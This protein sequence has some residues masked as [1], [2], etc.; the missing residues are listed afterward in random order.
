M[1]VCYAFFFERNEKLNYL[2]FEMKNEQLLQHTH[3]NWHHQ[4]SEKKNKHE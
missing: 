3:P 2:D 4:K 1:F